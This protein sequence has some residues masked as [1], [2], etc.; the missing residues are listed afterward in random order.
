MSE[1]P[2]ESWHAQLRLAYER[3]AARTVLSERRHNGPLVVQKSLYPE[4]EAVCHNYILH[5]PAG[6]VGGDRLA[7]EV[8]VGEAA[9]VVLST[10]GA[11]KWYRS[12]GRTA[13]QHMLFDVAGILEWLPQ[14]TIFFPGTAAELDTRID[15][16]GAARYLGWEIYCF[17]R[18]AA[19]ERFDT[20]NVRQR[21]E[22]FRNGRLLWCEQGRIDGGD[23][24]LDSAAGLAG[25]AVAGTLVAAGVAIDAATI[26][27]LR[28]LRAGSG[29][30]AV[31]AFEE[32][33]LVRYLG[34]STEHAREVF[35]VARGILRPLVCGVPDQALRIWRT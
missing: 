15:L 22:I 35:A 31:T 7:L 26:E 11:A 25:E 27:A 19:S 29:R 13:A 33:L 5:P 12:A 21:F 3:R 9:H 32:L 30:L 14:E 34:P 10:P 4:G 23:G 20:G 8:R 24:L 16:A 1:L 18:P 28:A 6:I 2:P 17:G